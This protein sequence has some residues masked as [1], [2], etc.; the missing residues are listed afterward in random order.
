MKKQQ[1]LLL[2]IIALISTGCI[3]VKVDTKGSTEETSTKAATTTTAN[4]AVQSQQQTAAA[5]TVVQVVQ[6]PA[7]ANSSGNYILPYSDSMY[8][9][10]NDFSGWDKQSIRYALN[11]IYARHGRKF[12]SEDLRNYF[13]AQ[14]WYYGS[15]EPKN[16]SESVLNQYEKKNIELLSSLSSGASSQNV[17]KSTTA[18]A[19]GIQP[20]ADGVYI[21]PYTDSI[22]YSKSDFAGWD[23]QTIRYALNEIYARHGRRFRSSDLQNYFSAQPW[24]S[25]T[26]SS[27]DFN[28]SV[29][30]KYEKKNIELLSSLK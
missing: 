12:D 24:Y 10:A 23:K 19:T 8:Y 18:A 5:Q 22:Y 25:G 3:T 29:L 21:L 9:S 26:V 2:G 28:E 16:F 13:S 27:D 6:A 4:S 15:I 30:N 11:E 14:S 20:F 7:Q 1:I 17:A